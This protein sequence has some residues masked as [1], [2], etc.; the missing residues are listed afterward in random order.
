MTERKYAVEWDG[1]GIVRCESGLTLTESFAL[2]L[3]LSK[4]GRTP[5]W[6]KDWSGLRMTLTMPNARN[7]SPE[8][9]HE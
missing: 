5:K 3:R 7:P 6:S 8:G 9:S 4:L 1:G 2:W